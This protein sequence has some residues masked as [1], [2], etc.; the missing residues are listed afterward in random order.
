MSKRIVIMVVTA[1]LGAALLSLLGWASVRSGGVPGGFLTNNTLGEVSVR[2]EIAA[3]FT[4]TTLN[5]DIFTLSELKGRVVMINFWASWCPPCRKEAPAFAQVYRE[6]QGKPVEFFGVDIWNREED[7]K[8]YVEQFE[9]PY[10]NAL[11]GGGR[12]AIDYGVT[13]IPETYFIGADGNLK[14]KFVGPMNE[15]RL[16]TVLNEMLSQ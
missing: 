3:D 4:V 7:A 15:E 11:D 12:I 6:Y 16:R 9:V 10:P 2:T 8:D 5:G 14:R 1:L 13:G